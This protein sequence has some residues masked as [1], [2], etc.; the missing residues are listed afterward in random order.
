MR[1]Q[2]GLLSI[3]FIG[4][5]L[6]A[7]TDFQKIQ[8][9]LDRVEE[10][11]QESLSEHKEKKAKGLEAAERAE[12]EALLKLEEHRKQDYQERIYPSSKSEPARY[13]RALLE[14]NLDY[15][16]RAH[17]IELE[18]QL[19]EAEV[20]AQH[21]IGALK[22]EAQKFKEAIDTLYDLSAFEASEGADRRVL[23]W[24]VEKKLREQEIRHLK[25]ALKIEKDYL[26]ELAEGRFQLKTQRIR[27]K[28]R[29]AYADPDGID[30]S[31]IVI[32]DLEKRVRK[33]QIQAALEKKQRL[34]ELE[35]ENEERKRAIRKDYFK[36]VSKLPGDYSIEF[37]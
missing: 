9:R 29:M 13:Q 8:S 26:E 32:A 23:D 27:Q 18:R 36:S 24:T 30:V 3:L 31:K 2:F 10:R 14:F 28:H 4:S 34:Q 5:S 21:E 12:A 37:E 19:K 25:A 35:I 33:E 20:R 16:K 6:Q 22:L 17:R 11:F 1:V 15:A 7:E